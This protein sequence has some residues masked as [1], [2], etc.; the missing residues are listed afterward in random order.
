MQFLT[1]VYYIPRSRYSA[2]YLLWRISK[3][4][5]RSKEVIYQLAMLKIR[6][7]SVYAESMKGVNEEEGGMGE[8]RREGIRKGIR[9]VDFQEQCSR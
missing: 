8:A 4:Y 7:P 6:D 1:K 9:L 2:S 3:S 5:L